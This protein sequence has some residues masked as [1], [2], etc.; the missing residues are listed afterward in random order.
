MKHLILALLMATAISSMA[1]N[2]GQYPE[3]NSIKLEYIGGG[4]VKV[5]NKQSCPSVIT[6]ND[7]KTEGNFNVPG[8]SFVIY[9]LPADLLTNIRIK[10]KNTTNCGN[11]DYGFVELFLSS[12][13]VTFTSFSV[14]KESGT[15]YW[16]NFNIENPVNVG[17]YDIMVSTDGKIWQRVTSI[18]PTTNNSY[19]VK[20]DLKN[21]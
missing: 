18:N 9:I 5:T 7:S 17:R 16:V 15:N 14:K 2:G 13:P 12:L 8:N 3:N 20:I 6:L 4:Q 19:S 11:S 1:Q 21:Q 10:A